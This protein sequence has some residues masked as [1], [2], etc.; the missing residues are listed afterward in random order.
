[1]VSLPNWPVECR[2]QG[3]AE[4]QPEGSRL[5]RYSILA[6]NLLWI[7]QWQEEERFE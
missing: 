6:R 4:H 3:A 1:M 7:N 5:P 2:P